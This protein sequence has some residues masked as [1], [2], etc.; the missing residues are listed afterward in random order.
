MPITDSGLDG[1]VDG[2]E[3]AVEDSDFADEVEIFIL[4]EFDYALKDVVFI[5]LA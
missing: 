5:E 1:L 3:V 2:I 4:E